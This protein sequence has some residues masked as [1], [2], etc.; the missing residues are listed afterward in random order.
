MT[1]ATRAKGGDELAFFFLSE[2]LILMTSVDA[3]WK[4]GLLGDIA[5]VKYAALTLDHAHAAI[6]SF[7]AYQHSSDGAKFC[8]ASFLAKVGSLLSHDG[9]KW[10]KRAHPLRNAM[11]HY[12]FSE[13]IVPRIEKGTGPWGVMDVACRQ[14]MGD[15]AAQYC[16]ELAAIR[17]STVEAIWRLIEFP[18]A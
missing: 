10:I 13:R 17:N 3:L 11:M 6:N 2:P 12:D 9:K 18:R 8:G 14:V 1:K 15:S 7:L 5:W 16:S 4:A